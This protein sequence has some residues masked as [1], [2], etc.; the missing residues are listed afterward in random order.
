[1]DIYPMRLYLQPASPSTD[2][3][4]YSGPTLS[5][6]GPPGIKSIYSDFGK[7]AH[8]ADISY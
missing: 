3:D 7:A 1:M 8:A 6:R 5:D 2:L 4:E